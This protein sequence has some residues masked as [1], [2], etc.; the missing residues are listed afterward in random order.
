MP[1]LFN[2]GVVA[3]ATKQEAVFLAY[4]GRLAVSFF[5]GPLVCG[6]HA[7]SRNVFS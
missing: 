3:G 2:L 7:T 6:E 1:D 5:P 4:L